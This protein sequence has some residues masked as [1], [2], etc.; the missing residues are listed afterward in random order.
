MSSAVLSRWATLVVNNTGIL[1]ARLSQQHFLIL[2]GTPD[3][4]CPVADSVILGLFFV[5]CH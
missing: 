5:S 4:R 3:S 1:Q 2:Y